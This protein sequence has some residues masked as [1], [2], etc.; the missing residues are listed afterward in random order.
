[1]LAGLLSLL[2]T[3]TATAGWEVNY[4]DTFSGHGVNWENWTAQIDANFNNEVQCYTDD[5]SSV[6]KKL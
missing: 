1:M 6:N 4:I 3:T 5:D 2:M